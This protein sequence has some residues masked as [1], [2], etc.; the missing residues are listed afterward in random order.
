M[1]SWSENIFRVTGLL[2]GE[3]T[4]HL[5]I[6]LKKASDA[7]LWCFLWSA[8]WINVCVNNGEA[9]D[10]R[11]HRAQYDVIV[12]ITVKHFR[13]INTTQHG[14]KC[15][16][17]LSKWYFPRHICI[18]WKHAISFSNDNVQQVIKVI[19][20]IIPLMCVFVRYLSLWIMYIGKW[21]MTINT[22]C[23]TLSEKET[24]FRAKNSL[25]I[26]LSIAQTVLIKVFISHTMTSLNGNI[27]RVTGHLSGEFAGP[28]W[29][30]HTK[31]SDAELWCFLDLRLNKRLSKQS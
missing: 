2:C 9:G 4:D 17:Q 6:P 30:P 10:L 12:M 1:T 5:W 8:P 11:R 22:V 15:M 28:R 27:F 7:E 29:I 31:V 13:T 14:A 20:N 21:G 24:H 26:V 19:A 25:I 23:A 3:F 18:Q 16:T